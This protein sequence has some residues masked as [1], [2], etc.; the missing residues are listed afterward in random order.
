R[1]ERGGRRVRSAAIVLAVLVAALYGA[2]VYRGQ[3][4]ALVALRASGKLGL[5]FVPVLALAILLM[6][7][8][9]ALLPGEVIER[10]LSDAAGWRGILIGWVAGILT[11]AGSLIGLPLAGGLYKA[12]VSPAVLVTF[13]TSLATLSLVKLPIEIGLLGLRLALVRFAACLVLPLA[14]GGVT[15]LCAA[16]LRG[17]P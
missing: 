3:G 12:G 7:A 6:G 4:E 14:A 15:R 16:L 17:G 8:V 9:E 2:L 1:R 10:W 13:L 5:S 11:P